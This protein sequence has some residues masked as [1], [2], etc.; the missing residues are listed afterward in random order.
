[1]HHVGKPLFTTYGLRKTLTLNQDF[2]LKS[3]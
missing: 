3:D 2:D 1:M